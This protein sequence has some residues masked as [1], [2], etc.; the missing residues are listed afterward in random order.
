LPPVSNPNPT[1]NLSSVLAWPAA[2]ARER[3]RRAMGRLDL[4]GLQQRLPVIG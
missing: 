4:P 1:N 3:S 2:A